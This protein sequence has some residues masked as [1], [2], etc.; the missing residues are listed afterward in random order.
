MICLTKAQRD[1]LFRLFQRDFPS[2]VTPFRQSITRENRVTHA[3]RGLPAC[4][5]DTRICFDLALNQ[6]AYPHTTIATFHREQMS[7]MRCCLVQGA[8]LL[9]SRAMPRYCFHL[10]VLWSP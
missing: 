5:K 9:L 2:W 10:R 8:T 4:M 6:R 3:A 1:A 7:G